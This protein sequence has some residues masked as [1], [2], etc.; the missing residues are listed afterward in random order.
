M[1]SEEEIENFKFALFRKKSNEIKQLMQKFG[2]EIFFASTLN[3]GETPLHVAARQGDD[4][5]IEIFLQHGIDLSIRDDYRYTPVMHAASA[6][7]KSTVT[8]LLS[9]GASV[10]NAPESKDQNLLSRL[11]ESNPEIV[12]L[13]QRNNSKFLMPAS[14]FSSASESASYEHQPA[15]PPSDTLVSYKGL[16]QR[17]SKKPSSDTVPLLPKIA[18]AKNLGGIGGKK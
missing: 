8:L 5:T 6:A 10:D 12:E 15:G 17:K 1:I 4:D 18:A 9:H 14:L 7:Q 2:T 13:I 16:R 11:A 3:Q